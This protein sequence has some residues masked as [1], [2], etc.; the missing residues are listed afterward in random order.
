MAEGFKDGNIPKISN[1]LG[2][3]F[4][5]LYEGDIQKFSNIFHPESHLY[6]SDGE[7]VTDWPRSEYLEMISNR[8]SPSS[9]GLTRHD[10][11][12]S[13]NIIWVNITSSSIKVNLYYKK[14]KGCDFKKESNKLLYPYFNFYIQK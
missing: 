5:G 2:D 14:K 10:K 3:Y 11:I 4:D 1:L 6:F 8:P 7:T 9:Q 13:I 12:I